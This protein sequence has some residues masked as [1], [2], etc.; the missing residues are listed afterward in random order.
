VIVHV[1]VHVIVKRRF[2]VR[3]VPSEKKRPPTMKDVAELVGVS[4]QT[5]SAVVNNKPGITAETRDR[6]L[7][8]VRQLGYRPYSV[9]RSLRT[10]QT[11]TLALIVSDLSNPSF[12]TMASAAEDYTHRFGY[13]LTVH[14]THDDVEREANY[15]QSLTQRWIDGVLYVSAE[16]QLSSQTALEQADIPSVAIDRI[17]ENYSGPSV[18]LDNMKAGHIAAQHLIALGHRRIAHISGPTRLRVARERIAGFEEALA[19]QGIIPAARD[20]GNWTCDSGHVAMQRI[21]KQQPPPT[22]LFAANDR[23]AIGAMQAICETGL[24]VP[25][26]ISVIGLDDIEVA[27]YQNPPLTTVRQSFVEL[28]TLA[29]QLLLALIENNPPPQTQIVIDPVLIERRSTES[30]STK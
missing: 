5:V 13:S 30:L 9:A 24:S 2:E 8:A 3:S 11:R 28:A 23:M 7:E 29:I 20:E 27:A 26:D 22:A 14:N 15:I 19:A 10:G 12:G 6:V 17:P 1:I 4:I 18:T 21:L 25:G 16:D